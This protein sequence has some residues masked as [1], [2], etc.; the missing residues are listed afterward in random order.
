MKRS[1]LFFLVFFVSVVSAVAQLSLSKIFSNNMVLQRDEP[2]HIWG[3]GVPDNSLEVQFGKETI[4]II[5]RQDSIWG[6]FF[7][8]RKASTA[9]QSLHIASSKQKMELTNILIGD[10][11]LCIGQ[12]NMEWPTAKEMHF[13]QEKKHTDQPMLR[14]YN[15]TYAGKRIFNKSFTDSVLKR[16]DR[17]EFY[18][19]SWVESDSN[20]V[21]QMSA[22]GYYFGRKI[23][24]TE[25]VPIGLINMSIGG[26]PIETFIGRDCL[27][28]DTLFSS[29]VKGNWLYND[30][31][32]VWVRERGKQNVG[33]IQ[34]IHKDE[35]GPNH[36][37][38]PGFA[39]SAGIEPLFKM[40][41]K[42]VIWYQGESNAQEIERVNEYGKLQ[43]LMIEDYR[44]QW[45]QPE[46]PF[47]WVQLSSIDTANYKSNYWPEF[48]NE[49][50]KLLKE[51]KHGGMAVSSD[52]GSKNDVHPTNKK[53]VGLRLA[54][55][56]LHKSY[57]KNV[58][59]SGPLIRGATFKNGKVFMDFKNTANG[60]RTSDNKGVRG[61]SFDRKEL[62]SAKLNKHTV[63]IQSQEK[64][65]YIY[66]GWQSFTNANLVNSENLPASTFKLKVN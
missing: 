10:I 42:G 18:M 52:I 40:P 24:E 43:K 17:R 6:V 31:L 56:A 62:V 29:K 5:V 38:K 27:E 3:K 1:L 66:Y 37:F 2:I 11:W 58:F 9:P 45:K 36:A 20:T 14:F 25:Q 16:L 53:D 39:Y 30:A 63:E 54:R 13:E 4:T 59:P 33:D 47:Y 7:K 57:G 64:P 49:Q 41:I 22:V 34:V 51:I 8:K 65:K 15:P 35:L 61:F 12:S 19:G 50:R 26:A 48:R 55:W 28:E 44:T 21:K 60:L 32:P 46:L 23:L